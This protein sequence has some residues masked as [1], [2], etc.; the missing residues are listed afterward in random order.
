M[1]EPLACADREALLDDQSRCWRAGQ[2]LRVEDY[3]AAQPALRNHPD[4]LLDLIEHE[5]LLRQGWRADRY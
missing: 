1:S 5:A 3:L 2:V 4:V